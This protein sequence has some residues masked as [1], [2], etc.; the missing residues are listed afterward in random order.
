MQHESRMAVVEATH[1]LRVAV[2]ALDAADKTSLNKMAVHAV[3]KV[4]ESGEAFDLTE[5]LNQLYE[6]L[7]IGEPVEQPKG[8]FAGYSPRV[9]ND[10]RSNGYR[11]L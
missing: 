8:L 7:Q 3:Q 5:V 1:N 9:I 10:R 4:W 11:G 2:S 6:Q